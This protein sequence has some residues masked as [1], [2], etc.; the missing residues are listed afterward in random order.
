MG[1]PVNHKR[2]KPRAGADPTAAERRHHD[3]VRALGCLVSGRPATIHH[4]TGYADRIGRLPRSHRIVVPLA[5]EYHQHDHGPLSVERLSHRGFYREHGINL[6][7]E[8]KRLE[9]ESIELGI[10]PYG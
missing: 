10:L 5:P 7:K 6:L 9:Y 8:A 2:I 1:A 4:V 3:R